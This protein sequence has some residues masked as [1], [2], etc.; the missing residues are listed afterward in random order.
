MNIFKKY[1][2]KKSS[3]I[4]VGLV[5]L[6]ALVSIFVLSRNSPEPPVTP[7]PQTASV[8]ITEDGFAPL[9]MKIKAGTVVVW[10]NVDNVPHRIS[11]NPFGGAKDL[12]SLDSLTN[13]ASNSTYRYTFDK[14]GTYGYHDSLNPQSYN[15][16][17]IVE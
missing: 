8:S 7:V 12:P 10:T 17:I 11:S 15:G 16:T 1:G 3:T 13:M 9:S 4:I 5:I 6:L 2:S 14:P